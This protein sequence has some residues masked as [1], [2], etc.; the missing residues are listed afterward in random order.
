MDRR[1]H[2]RYRTRFDAFCSSGREEGEGTL[3]DLSY[4]G[5]RILDSPICPPEG[6]KV[7]LYLFVDPSRP[8]ELTGTVARHVEAGFA[9]SFGDLPSELRSLVDDFA[10]VVE[11]L[12]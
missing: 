6:T 10:A 11:P 9:L 8:F 2:P 12:D 7:R 3:H 1:T 4:A 5:A